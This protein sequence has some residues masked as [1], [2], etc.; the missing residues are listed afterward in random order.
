[1]Y[2]TKDETADSTS[3]PWLLRR[4]HKEAWFVPACLFALVEAASVNAL[5]HTHTY[6]ASERSVGEECVLYRC[7]HMWTGLL[8]SDSRVS[9]PGSFAECKLLEE[10][11][12]FHWDKKHRCSP[13]PL[14][15]PYLVFCSYIVKF[16]LIHGEIRA[17]VSAATG[18]CPCK[19]LPCFFRHSQALPGFQ[20]AAGFQ[21]W[22]HQLYV[23]L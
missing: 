19:L 17:L 20:R 6:W 15:Y 16:K 8:R 18:M 14:A 1:M 4:Q 12:Y 3:V 9:L 7:V 21:D 11:L 23:H 5:Y 10:A 22:H 2:P 13:L